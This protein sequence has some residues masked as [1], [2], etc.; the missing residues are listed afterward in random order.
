MK[1]LFHKILN[2]LNIN[3]RDWVVLILALLLAFSTWMIHNLSLKY[4]DY[5]K[6]PVVAECD[7]K[8]HSNLSSNKAEVI[9]RCRATGYRVL[10]SA[11]RSRKVV[12][13]PFRSEDMVHLEGDTFYVTA[14]NLLE[15]AN[16]IY[17]PDVNVEYFLT[18]TLFFRFPY[19][20]FKKV[21]LV[22]ISTFSYRDQYMPDGELE[23]EPDSVLIYGEPLMIENIQEVY[24]KPIKFY[25]LAEDI[26]GVV[27]VEKV[28]GVRLSETEA[29]YRMGVKRYVEVSA[30]LPVKTVNVPQDKVMRV[31]PS[32]VEVHLRCNFPL[33][34]DPL[35]GI[36]VEAD[37]NDYL[38]SLGGNCILKAVGLT[39]GV[40]GC[41]IDPVA[42]SGVIED[43]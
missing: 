18:D 38:N 6:V 11:I 25:D 10:R 30:M 29:R 9:A 1:N 15:Y 2:A 33:V 43:R 34:D 22:P 7:I 17:G 35:R 37:Y 19:E 39:R 8:G 14:S 26:Q 24:T 40:I 36:R 5:L 12:E 31:Y 20:N 32:V 23:V 3:G 41:E 42:V 27:P 4:N 21:P 16:N 13:V 28:K